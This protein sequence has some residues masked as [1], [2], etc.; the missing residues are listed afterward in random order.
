MQSNLTNEIGSLSAKEAAECYGKSGSGYI[1]VYSLDG[2]SK[3]KSGFVKYA[4]GLKS[5]PTKYKTWKNGST[6]KQFMLILQE[7]QKLALFLHMAV[8]DVMAK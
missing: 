1:V 4:G 8:R 6:R 3:H 7:K 2:T 5:T